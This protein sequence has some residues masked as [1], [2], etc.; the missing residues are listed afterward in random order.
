MQKGNSA[1]GR[2]LGLNE[3]TVRTK[4]KKKGEI[5]ASVKAYGLLSVM[6]ASVWGMR[7]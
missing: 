6:I 4:W 3:S 2:A 7:N 1:I 5:K